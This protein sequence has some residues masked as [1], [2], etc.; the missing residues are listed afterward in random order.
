MKE[1]KI[2]KI[3]SLLFLFILIFMM[4]IVLFF[5]KLFNID[6]NT[7]NL[8]L[9]GKYKKIYSTVK[10]SIENNTS[11]NL[12]N[13]EKLVEYSY[14]YNKA[15]KYNLYTNSEES[16]VNLGNNYFSYIYSE[17]DVDYF[18]DGIN[19]FSNYLND[20]NINLLYVQIPFKISSD[21]NLSPVYN[22]STDKSVDK[23]LNNINSSIDYIDLRENIKK[24]NLNNLS[25]FFETDHHWLPE[26][27]LWA[28][29][30]ISNYI[31][32]KYNLNLETSNL[33]SDKY[34]YKKYRN[35]FLGTA[36]RKVSLANAELEDFT[37]IT[38]KFETKL[39]IT[40]NNLG[41]NKI[42][43]YDETLIDW[44]KLEYGDYYNISPY[45]AY[46][47]GDQ[48]LIEIHNELVNNNKKILL[49]KDSFAEVIS[50]FITLENEYLSILDL[51]YYNNSFKKY[52]EEYKPDIVIVMYNGSMISGILNEHKVLWNFE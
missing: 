11:E 41:I 48:P 4:I 21:L 10:T 30:I 46:M 26:T 3:G 31:N 33:D 24:E 13:Y 17:K 25:L 15:L 51:R 6:F 8:S 7:S 19:K 34:N 9:V 5:T 28:T 38:P 40:I 50:P 29:S 1:R 12:A 35:L 23:F 32:E 45:T 47:Y 42:G 44:S 20:K 22:D 36:G 43:T 27:G 37:L 14:I 2:E 52:I 39:H 18:V 16:T 49:I